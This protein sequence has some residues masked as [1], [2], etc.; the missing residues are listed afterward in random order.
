[1][2]QVTAHILILFCLLWFSA[3]RHADVETF[4]AYEED[5]MQTRELQ[6]EDLDPEN[7]AIQAEWLAPS[8][9]DYKLGV[10]D[11]VEIE[12]LSVEGSLSSTFIMPD[13]RVYYDLAGG[14]HADGLTDRTRAGGTVD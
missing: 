7:R 4:D 8:T 10:G 6:F 13:G 2:R 5:S 3:C 12:I 14:V 9:A 11:Q 1:M